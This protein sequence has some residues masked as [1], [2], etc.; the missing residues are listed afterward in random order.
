MLVLKHALANALKYGKA[1]FKSVVAKVFAERPELK[2]RAKEVVEEA[3]RVVEEVNGLVPEEIERRLRELAPEMMEREK[4]EEVKELPPLEGAVRGKVRVRLPP[5]PNGY[6]HIGHALS[7]H[8]NHLY[9]RRYDGKVILKFEDTNPLK[10]R[11]EYYEAIKRDIRWLGIE[12]DEVFVLSEHFRE[13]EKG[14]EAL[15]QEGRAYVCS[16]PSEEI[17]RGRREKRADPCRERS[18]RESLELWEGMKAGE[19][20]VLRW[21]G[22]PASENSVL[23]DPTLYR[24]LDAVHPH[25]GENHVVYPNYDYASAFTDGML[26]IT[27]VLRSEEFLMREPLHRAIIDA[28]GQKPPVYVHY[29]RFELEGTPTSKRLIRPLVEEGRVEGW[30]DP[31]LATIMGLRRRGIV[32][33]TFEDL[34][35]ATGPYRGSSLI[36]WK[37]LHG[38]NRKNIDPIAGRFFVVTEPVKLELEGPEREVELPVHPNRDMGVRRLRLRSPIYLE[39]GD[40]RGKLRLKG[41]YNVTVEGGRAKFAGEEIIRPIVHWLS[42]HIE[43]ELVVPEGLDRPLR[44][45]RVLAEPAI[46]EFKGEIIQ[47]ERI[48]FARIDSRSPLRLIKIE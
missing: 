10:E 35:V 29:G 1:D 37:L 17:S 33:K 30:D 20:L 31:R 12:W 15:I 48:G 7:F 41:G 38:L 11:P 43:A 44:K 45:L 21:K 47:M 25:T 32:P 27:H 28:A 34:A 4:R 5:E 40:A 42:E 8:L 22:D 18:S 39:K 9:A 46:R 14:A 6:L 13:L 23:R 2:K 26:R 16:C 19:R 36:S 3:R 24:V